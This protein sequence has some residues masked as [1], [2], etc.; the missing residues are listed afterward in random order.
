MIASGQVPRYTGNVMN[1]FCRLV[2]EQGMASLWRGNLCSVLRYFPLELSNWACRDIFK[3]MFPRY[4]RKKYFWSWF[5]AN[6]ASESLGGA[7]SLL[8]VYPL[9]F[10]R[11]RL[12]CDIGKDSCREFSG[13]IDCLA[14]V[15]EKDGFFA[16]YDGFCISVL[17]LVVSR[18]AYLL[19][20]DYFHSN[21]TFGHLS[22]YYEKLLIFRFSSWN[23]NSLCTYLWYPMDTVSRRLIMQSG[24][25]RKLYNGTLDCLAKVW[26]SDG[27]NSFFKGSNEHY[28]HSF[29]GAFMGLTWEILD[30]Y[31]EQNLLKLLKGTL[32]GGFAAGVSKTATA[33]FGE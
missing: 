19:L 17:G 25:E 29:L 6:L 2:S 28:L 20:N 7:F 9:D 3:P 16:L 27:M 12:A 33:P 18:A 8:M 31:M 10:A 1:C 11:T 30:H 24:S 4:D 5:S 23:L 32:R 26:Q 13:I 15:A 14:K 22:G 21:K